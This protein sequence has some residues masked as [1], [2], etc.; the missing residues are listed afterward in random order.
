MFETIVKISVNLLII[1]ILAACNSSTPNTGTKQINSL[2]NCNMYQDLSDPQLSQYMV[3]LSFS[4]NESQVPTASNIQTYT[5]NNYNIQPYTAQNASLDY[6]QSA[7][8]WK[9]D[10]GYGKRI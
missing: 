9:V 10:D 3:N 4:D 7:Y 1:V 5:L 8:Y 2:A 6:I